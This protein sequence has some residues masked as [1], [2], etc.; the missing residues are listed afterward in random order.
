LAVRSAAGVALGSLGFS[1][2]ARSPYAG[3]HD[4]LWSWSPYVGS[5]LVWRVAPSFG[6]RAD[7]AVGVDA[8]H[9]VVR[10]AGREV[11]DWGRPWLAGSAALELSWP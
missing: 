7:V 5:G 3:V 2:A 10:F 6:L 8:S 11:A 9:T 1:G 4:H